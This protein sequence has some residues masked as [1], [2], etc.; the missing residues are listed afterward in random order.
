MPLCAENYFD[1]LKSIF[2]DIFG[3]K[4]NLITSYEKTLLKHNIIKNQQILHKLF[5]VYL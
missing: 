2:R 1:L 5:S 3:E 4:T